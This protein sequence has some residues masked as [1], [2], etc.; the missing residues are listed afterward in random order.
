MT[1]VEPARTPNP[2]RH[3]LL[4]E[5]EHDIQILLRTALEDHGFYV[6]YTAR[7]SDARAI[8]E[9]IKIDLVIANVILPDGNSLAT[10][11][12]AKQ[13]GIPTILMTGSIEHMA[14]LEANGEYYL[15]KPFTLAELVAQVQSHLGRGCEAAES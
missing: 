10:I 2:M 11:E 9:R 4:L 5:D 8:L 13:K 14:R 6:T 15:A 1:E 7:V 12:F 3:I